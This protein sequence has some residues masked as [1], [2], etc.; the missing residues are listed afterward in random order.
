MSTAG[1]RRFAQ[2][3]QAPDDDEL[4]GSLVDPPPAGHATWT[5]WAGTRLP[6]LDP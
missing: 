4:T 2:L 3:F 5:Q 6:Y 1:L